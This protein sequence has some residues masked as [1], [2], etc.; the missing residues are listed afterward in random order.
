[1]IWFPVSIS[2]NFFQVYL[3]IFLCQSLNSVDSHNPHNPQHDAFLPC[4]NH[5]KMTTSY[6]PSLGFSGSYFSSSCYPL[7]PSPSPG[8]HPYPPSSSLACL[9]SSYLAG[10][11]P[12][13]F[14]SLHPIWQVLP[15]PFSV[16]TPYPSSPYI[17]TPGCGVTPHMTG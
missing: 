10:P 14:S 9:S 7:Y 5:L 12:A 13:P 6:P 4:T 2:L 15:A 8:L 3:G 1:M 17:H 11:L 16:C